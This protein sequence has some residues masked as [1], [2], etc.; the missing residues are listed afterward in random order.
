M[1]Y[2]TK[3]HWTLLNTIYKVS[4]RKD[5]TAWNSK[6]ERISSLQTNNNEI[7]EA[8]NVVLTSWRLCWKESLNHVLI[9]CN[10][11]AIWRQK[12]KLL[13]IWH[14]NAKEGTNLMKLKYIM[15]QGRNPIRPN[16]QNNYCF[17]SKLL[18]G[19]TNM[20]QDSQKM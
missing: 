10:C 3:F 8:S 11:Q 15:F 14:E 17:F 6:W 2:I 18:L 19:V 1:F 7:T 12:Q 5:E 9:L 13:H 16:S 4:I 20:F